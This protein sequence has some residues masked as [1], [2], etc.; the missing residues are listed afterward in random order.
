LTHVATKL[1]PMLDSIPA[2]ISIAM[3]QA[4]ADMCA[5]PHLSAEQAATVGSAA[6][7]QLAVSSLSSHCSQ[8]PPLPSPSHTVCSH[9]VAFAGSPARHW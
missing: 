5:C 8:R 3:L 4:L 9:R 2:S 7:P 1:L 6:V